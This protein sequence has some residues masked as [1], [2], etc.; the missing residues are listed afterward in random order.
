MSVLGRGD[1]TLSATTDSGSGQLV[2]RGHSLTGSTVFSAEL[3]CVLVFR[4][5]CNLS[6]LSSP[7]KINVSLS[8]HF[9]NITLLQE[10]PL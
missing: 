7:H 6:L 4:I 9:P 1:K 10:G 5:S 2:C 8:A 3:S